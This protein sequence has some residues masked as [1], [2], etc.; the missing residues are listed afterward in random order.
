MNE[1]ALLDR[2]GGIGDIDC[3][4]GAIDLIFEAIILADTIRLRCVLPCD[5]G[6]DWFE[7]G[8]LLRRTLEA[9]EGEFLAAE[10]EFL[11][12]EGEYMTVCLA[13]GDECVEEDLVKDL[14]WNLCGDR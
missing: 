6:D 9:A 7:D 10:G 3:A 1:T 11:A 4:T 8:L 12:A 2:Y 14:L 13:T 5:K